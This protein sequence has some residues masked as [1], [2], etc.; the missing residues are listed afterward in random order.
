M[1]VFNRHV[2]GRAITIFSIEAVLI[3]LSIVLAERIHGVFP[4]GSSHAGRVLFIAGVCTLCFYYNDL[5]NLTVV[6]A[7][8]DLLLHILRGAGVA[9]IALGVVTV[10]TPA[11][12]IDSSTSLT[13]IGLLLVAVPSWRLVFDGVSTDS[14]L[15][16]RVLMLGTGPVARLVAREI[17]KQH[18]FGYHIVG[19]V[20]DGNEPP[21]DVYILGTTADLGTIVA[22]HRIDR[23]VV[24]L[25]DGRG[26]LPIRELLQA[27]LAG[28]RVEEGAT[29]YERIAG[30]VLLDQLKPS[31]LVFSAGFR[32]SRATRAAKRALDVVFATFG[33][34]AGSPLML[35]TA[36]AIR[37]ESAGPILYRQERVGAGGCAFTVLKFRSM[38]IDAESGTPIWAASHDSRITRV[39]RFIRTTRLDELPQLWNVLRGEMSFVGPRPERRFFVD[40]LEAEIPFYAE[41]H[42]VRPGITGWA[43]V[44][45]HYGA[46]IEDA[47]EKLRYDLYYIKHLSI[48]FDLTI[49]V[50]TV[51]VILV[52]K[53]AQ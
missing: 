33:L 21:N 52:G 6:H 18:D 53:G 14:P 12:V 31:W 43:Q 1:Q 5:Y 17:A 20:D 44:R 46:S 25:T 27:K 24:A 30:K 9:A 4:G 32:A 37:L 45:Y 47:T 38:A 36:L 42:T 35:M 40:R 19:F 13:A 26:R 51:R 41:R 7:K 29:T 15:D 10:L 34:V 11:L 39:G 22:R 49:F 8:R 28:V 23:I 16:E 2:S 3:V 50:D 48:G